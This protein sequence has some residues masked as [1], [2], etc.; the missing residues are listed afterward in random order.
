LRQVISNLLA[1]AVKFSP[2]GSTVTLSA[3]DDPDELVIEVIDEGIGIPA[4]DQVHIFDDFFRA[5]N[6][7]EI[8]GAGLGLSIAQ[9]IVDA[10]EGR[11]E[12]ESP[13][14]EGKPGS[15]FTVF[16]P[17]TLAVPGG[18]R[19]GASSAEQHIEQ[20]KGGDPAAGVDGGEP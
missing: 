8:G 1:N 18:G 14:E 5:S 4:E 16:I 13:Y 7:A 17:R 9:K 10:H 20:R 11:I 6:A 12:I 2:E 3:R 19:S 15:K